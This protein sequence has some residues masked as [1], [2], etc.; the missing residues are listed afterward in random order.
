MHIIDI[1]AGIES[2]FY[3]NK[4]ETDYKNNFESKITHNKSLL[5]GFYLTKLYVLES[6]ANMLEFDMTHSGPP[7][8][9]VFA[10]VNKEFLTS[11]VN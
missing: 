9:L 5:L 8:N 1:E 6:I 11:V 10:T 3:N 4:F 7:A 2:E